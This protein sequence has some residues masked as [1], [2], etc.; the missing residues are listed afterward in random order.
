MCILSSC[1][2]FISPTL[3]SHRCVF[4]L[5]FNWGIF[6]AMTVPPRMSRKPFIL[7]PG[8]PHLHYD[9]HIW[10]FEKRF[11]FIFFR[12]RRRHGE[13]ERNISVGLPL[14]QPLLGTQTTTQAC[15]L[16]ESRTGHYFSSKVG[17]QP[18]EPHQPGHIWSLL[19]HYSVAHG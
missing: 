14:A 7:E 15:T 2:K 16:T 4:L 6:A 1:K 11:Y 19:N 8:D 9:L 13:R 10:N 3:F 18:T 12:E 5:V 17:T